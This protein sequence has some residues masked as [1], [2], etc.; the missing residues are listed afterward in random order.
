M[1]RL[2]AR[3]HHVE[4]KGRNYDHTQWESGDIPNR[5]VSAATACLYGV[6]EAAIL[7]AGYAP[8]IGF[9]HTGKPQ[10][11]VYDIGDVIKFDTVV[12]IAFRVA[13]DGSG[14]PETAVRHACRDSFR[15]DRV[16]GRIIPLIQEILAA[17][18]IEPPAA[19][20]DQVGPAFPEPKDMGDGGHRL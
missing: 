20:S 5:C 4:W 10:S 14:D 19:G 18:G 17:G 11:F 12:P 1:Y 7:A 2:L 15:R 13:K 16:L 3:Q 6:C 8:A 9:I